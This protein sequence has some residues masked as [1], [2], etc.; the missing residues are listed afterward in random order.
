M[1]SLIGIK[2]I[3]S[4]SPLGQTRE[5]ILGAY[6]DPKSYILKKED[7][8]SWKAQLNDSSKEIFKKIISW[9]KV[10]SKSDRSLLMALEAADQCL[11]AA[12][13]KDYSNVG[14]FF[15]S[16]RGAAEQLELNH[17]LFLQ[18]KAIHPLTS[19]LTTMGNISAL[20][21][22]QFG[23][24]GFTDT[25]SMTCSSSFHALL[26]AVVWIESGMKSKMIVG[27]TE[28]PLTKFFIEQLKSL[29]LYSKLEGAY[30]NRSLDFLKTQNTMVLGEGAACLAIEK[31]RAEENYLALISGIGYGMENAPN[32]TGLS[33]EADNIQKAMQSALEGH[34]PKS[35][36]I[37]VCHA[38]GTIKGD[39]SEIAAIEKV[40]ADKIPS[41]TS[42]K[43][44][45]GHTLG[46]SGVLSLEMAV[47]MLQS[48]KVFF[49]PYLKENQDIE[50]RKIMINTL[51][52]GG[53]AISLILEINN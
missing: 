23:I 37:I 44:K 42:N 7:S 6:L 19:P 51:G 2:S 52:F 53:N 47:L 27:G 11:K 16:S 21:A 41:L 4:I 46:A 49:P 17:A 25:L 24:G 39:A 20:V 10:Y 30:P 45:M 40:F 18:E 13:W 34:D 15:G 1:N 32:I 29:G 38:P 35:V 8:D 48:K 3:G 43:W 22:R 9:D 26:H 36:D 50:P 5:E 33:P 12:E 14:V 28:A 31:V